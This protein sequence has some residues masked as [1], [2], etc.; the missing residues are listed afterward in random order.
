M[1]TP[2]SIMRPLLVASIMSIML[3]ACGESSD[4]KAGSQYGEQE[5]DTTNPPVNTTFNQRALL[6][7]IADNIIAPTYQSFQN[8]ALSQQEKVA[9]YCQLQNT[10]NSGDSQDALNSALNEARQAWRGAMNVWQYAEMM[11]IGPLTVNSSTLRNNIYSWPLVSS[12]S[13]DQDVMYFAQGSINSRPYKIA[14]RTATRRGLDALEYLLFNTKTEHSCSTT[15]AILSTWLDKSDQQRMSLRCDFASEVAKDLHNNASTLVSQWSG[16]NGYGA[17][18]KQAGEQDS[19]FASA[20][21]GINAVSDALFYLDKITKDAKLAK[22]LGFSP[23]KC[24]SDCS[25]FVESPY[26]VHALPNLI[27]NL[28]AFRLLF[29]GEGSDPLNT[30][31][32]DDYLVDVDDKAT[33]IKMLADTDA[34]IAALENIGQSLAAALKEDASNA[35]AAHGEVKNVT[36]QLKTDFINSLALKLPKTAA[37]DND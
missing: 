2:N 11:Q 17:L 34:A 14:N 31:G 5:P 1:N 24:S 20:H 13:V 27:N 19:K 4:S 8:K 29:N 16:D 6:A 28:R 37:G 3:S 33:A 36:D 9:S 30:L 32:F 22:P 35:E 23:D 10:V 15:N 18:L 26:S 21:E 12:C 25:E 7:N